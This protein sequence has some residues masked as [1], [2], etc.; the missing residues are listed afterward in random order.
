MKVTNKGHLKVADFERITLEIGVD[1]NGGSSS[2]NLTAPHNIAY[3]NSITHLP[4]SYVNYTLIKR[5]VN[6]YKSGRIWAWESVNITGDGLGELREVG[7]PSNKHRD[8]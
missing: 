8:V 3:C 7:S 5:I 4:I 1:N 6:R 2:G